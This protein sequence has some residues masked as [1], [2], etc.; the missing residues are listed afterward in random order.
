MA[1]ERRTGAAPEALTAA[2]KDLIVRLPAYA[3]LYWRLLRGGGLSLRQ[4]ALAIGSL[5]YI[6]SPI[7]FVPGIIPVV[8]QMDDIAVALLGLRALL[9]GM[10]PA[11]AEGHLASVGLSRA[12]LDADL[13]T[14]GRTALTLAKQGL[15]IAGKVA[16]AGARAVTQVTG[17]PARRRR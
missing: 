11:T 7:D 1:E 2:V 15:R 4:R 10:P 16:V 12:Q 8:G 14:L 9:R 6:V 3:R 13:A 17:G 5:A